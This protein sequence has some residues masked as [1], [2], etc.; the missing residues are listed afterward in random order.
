MEEEEEAETVWKTGETEVVDVSLLK[1][2]LL[3][4]KTGQGD[5]WG[6]RSHL[7]PR[8]GEE[9]LELAWWTRA[10]KAENAQ[11]I[12]GEGKEWIEKTLKWKYG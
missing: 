5:R 1:N 6:L 3:G 4:E 10:E 11:G 7:E 8:G 12:K 9:I 2:C